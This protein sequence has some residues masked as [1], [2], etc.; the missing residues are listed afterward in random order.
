MRMLRKETLPKILRRVLSIETDQSVF[1]TS[2]SPS[3]RDTCKMGET[4]P[5]LKAKRCGLGDVTSAVRELEVLHE[6]INEPVSEEEF[7]LLGKNVP[8]Q[9][10]KCPRNRLF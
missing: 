1:G 4:T 8:M 5:L 3:K 2:R 10:K 6:A 7:D 9:L